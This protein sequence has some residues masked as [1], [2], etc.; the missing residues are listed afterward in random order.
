M[1]EGRSPKRAAVGQGGR[2]LGGIEDQLDAAILD[3][4]HDMRPAFQH[5]VDLGR[6]YALL[7]EI[8]LSAR[9]GD[10]GA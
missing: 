10:D 5:F 7:R 9:R 3:G 4:V 8:S 6:L 1:Q 2:A